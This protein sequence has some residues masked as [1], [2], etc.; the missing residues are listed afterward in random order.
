MTNDHYNYCKNREMI[1]LILFLPLEM[2]NIELVYEKV[3]I[4]V[5]NIKS[6]LNIF[7]EIGLVVKKVSSIEKTEKFKILNYENIKD[8]FL[9]KKTNLLL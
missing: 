8:S 3:K 6:I 4:Y 5:E 1:M 7:N 9:E 2:I